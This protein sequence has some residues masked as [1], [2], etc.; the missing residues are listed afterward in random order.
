MPDGH[1][2]D[3]GTHALR[4]AAR[5]YGTD[6]ERYDRTRPR[7]PDALVE[8]VIAAAPD[9]D[10]LDVG[11]GTGI[12][13]LAFQAAGCTV[14]GVEPDPRM[15]ELARRK[16][17]EVE[18]ATFEGWDPAGRTFGALVS[19][20]AWHW[21]DPVAGA[22]KAATALRPGGRLALFW[23]AF[24]P[25]PQVARAF[26]AVYARVL[27]DL[28]V[29]QRAMAGPDSHAGMVATASDGIA[30]TGAF[31]AVEQWRFDWSRPYT[32]DQ[33][34]DQVP[35]F[36][37]NGQLPPDRLDALLTGIGDAVDAMGGGFTMDY[38]ALVVTSTRL[39]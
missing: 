34:L 3:D 16:G 30:R 4:D 22:A 13:G 7:Y 39:P 29:L 38:T 35:T 24:R 20:T 28:P 10:V 36:G 26:G 25:A 1:R 31:G 19:G 33:W 23:N 15:A 17:L 18:V 12:A 5:S 14:L 9:R 8:R 11:A 37:G 27:P 21:I 32:R 2:P 6:A